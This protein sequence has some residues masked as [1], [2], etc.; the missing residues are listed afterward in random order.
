MLGEEKEMIRMIK[1]RS[2]QQGNKFR[3]DIK[4]DKRSIGDE[5]HC[6][7]Y[8]GCDGGIHLF[9]AYLHRYQKKA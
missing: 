9:V 2:R 5:Y 3:K 7:Y 1:K 6:G 8:A 4:D